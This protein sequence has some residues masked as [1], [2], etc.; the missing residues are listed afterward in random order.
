MVW[1]V[2]YPTV[3]SRSKYSIPLVSAVLHGMT[4]LY[5]YIVQ[6]CS[7]MESRQYILELSLIFLIFVYSQCIK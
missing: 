1:K 6:I 2:K 4:D 7:C 3:L 5:F